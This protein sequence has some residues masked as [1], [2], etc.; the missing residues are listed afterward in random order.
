MLLKVTA[1]IGFFITCNFEAEQ[2]KSIPVFIQNDYLYAFGALLFPYLSG[3][4]LSL[5][6]MYTPK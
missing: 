5:L 2:R 1:T 4:L 6:M 3:Y